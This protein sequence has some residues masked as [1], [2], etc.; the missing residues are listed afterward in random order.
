MLRKSPNK[1][2]A[3]IYDFICLP[4][5]KNPSDILINAEIERIIEMMEDSSNKEYS[6]NYLK[7]ITNEYNLNLV[8]ILPNE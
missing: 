6:E 8:N 3:Y 4:P 7:E 2:H 5:N 1:D